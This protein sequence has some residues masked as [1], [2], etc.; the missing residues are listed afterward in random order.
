MSTHTEN[1]EGIALITVR[2]HTHVLTRVLDGV[3]DLEP[4]VKQL[5]LQ[6]QESPF[7]LADVIADSSLSIALSQLGVLYPPSG[8]WTQQ[9]SRSNEGLAL[10]PQDEYAKWESGELQLNCDNVD[11]T[12]IM[13]VSTDEE[14]VLGFIQSPQRGIVNRNAIVEGVPK[15]RELRITE[16]AIDTLKEKGL[17][18]EE[19]GGYSVDMNH[20]RN[21]M[22]VG[23]LVGYSAGVIRR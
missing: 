13:T 6:H 12:K 18:R 16:K 21:Y 22:V 19:N 23:N 8:V 14:D 10:L 4:R 5:W 17:L 3:G 2:D 9:L 1:Y 15:N 7:N 11:L 20:L